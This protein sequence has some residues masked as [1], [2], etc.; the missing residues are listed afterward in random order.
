MVISTL[1]RTV[2]DHCSMSAVIDHLKTGFGSWSIRNRTRSTAFFTAKQTRKDQ[3]AEDESF[4]RDAVPEKSS[5]AVLALLL[6]L[7]L[8]GQWRWV[9]EFTRQDL[10]SPSQTQTS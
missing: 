8:Y 10:R 5:R 4:G 1:T 2:T 3:S 7:T 9:S 6:R